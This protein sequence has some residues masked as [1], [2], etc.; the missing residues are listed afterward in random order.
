VKDDP[1]SN[2]SSDAIDVTQICN[3]RN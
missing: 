3:S 1:R 2:T